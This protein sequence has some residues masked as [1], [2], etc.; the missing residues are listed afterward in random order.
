MLQRVKTIVCLAI[1]VCL[2]CPSILAENVYGKI[3]VQLEVYNMY[4]LDNSEF[5]LIL[6]L[7]REDD[8]KINNDQIECTLLLPENMYLVSQS[9]LN[10]K[11]RID[12]KVRVSSPEEGTRLGSFINNKK[13]K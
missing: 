5:Y 11:G 12:F 3:E 7:K 6:R 2:L 4:V 13:D 10:P 1:I 8:Q 9:N